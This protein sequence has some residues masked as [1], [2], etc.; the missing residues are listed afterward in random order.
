[1]SDSR[2]RELERRARQGDRQAGVQ[3]LVERVRVGSLDSKRLELAADLGCE[4]AHKALGR[5]TATAIGDLTGLVLVLERWEP[6]L[7]IRVL[8]SGARVFLPRFQRWL[9]SE[10]RPA[11][12]LEAAERWLAQPGT[13]VALACERAAE[14]VNSSLA[15]AVNPE[16]LERYRMG[17][18]SRHQRT[19]LE[20]VAWTARDAAL[21][22]FRITLRRHARLVVLL[23]PTG[24]RQ[25]QGRVGR[26]SRIPSPPPT[27]PAELGPG[28]LERFNS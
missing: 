3:L 15:N 21:G 20:Y 27:P 12:A 25:P 1:M 14:N 7:L 23:D 16:T 13:E 26:R 2:L 24:G 19:A 10:K 5:S 6:E 18:L 28:R 22:C 11:L 17:M 8:T 9:P 4:Q